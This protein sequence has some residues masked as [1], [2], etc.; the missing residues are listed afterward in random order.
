MLSSFYSRYCVRGSVF[1]EFL[2]NPIYH[3]KATHVKLTNFRLG[4][5]ILRVAGNDSN[6]LNILKIIHNLFLCEHTIKNRIL[7]G[8]LLD[9]IIKN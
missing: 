8:A 9:T 1:F 2:R 4:H 7:L 3:S 5:H 6:Y